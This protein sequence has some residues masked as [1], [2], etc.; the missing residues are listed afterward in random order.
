MDSRSRISS[1]RYQKEASGFIFS[2]RSDHT[3]DSNRFPF[4]LLL[5]IYAPTIALLSEYGLNL[6][7]NIIC[8]DQTK[9]LPSLNHTKT[10]FAK[11]I[12]EGITRLDMSED[13][14][15]IPI[16]LDSLWV[17]HRSAGLPRNW[18]WRKN[19]YFSMNGF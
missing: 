13:V 1:L 4:V 11:M 16:L 2:T 17:A 6:V 14:N 8:L 15:L 9:C 3:N 7:V 19:N 10:V 12:N 18:S 5:K